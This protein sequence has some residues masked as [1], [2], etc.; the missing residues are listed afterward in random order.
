MRQSVTFGF[1]PECGRHFGTNGM[2][3]HRKA[4]HGVE[5]ATKASRKAKKPTLTHEERIARILAGQ[6]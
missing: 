6:V 4:K 5:P 3:R 1:C 2:A